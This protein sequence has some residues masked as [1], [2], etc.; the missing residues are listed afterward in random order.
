MHGGHDCFGAA[1]G[2]A[3]VGSRLYWSCIG[4]CRGVHYCFGA[5]LG[6]AGVVTTVLVLHWV[7]Q[8]WS[9]LF[10]CCTGSCRGG[11]DYVEA[12]LGHARVVTSRLEGPS[13]Q[14]INSFFSFLCFFWH[15][16]IRILQSK[17]NSNPCGSGSTLIL[18][19][20]DQKQT[21][22][23]AEGWVYGGKPS[24]TFSLLLF[25]ILS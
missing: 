13:K 23:T 4:S 3:G 16:W 24:A 18:K 17:I 10:W 6:H 5:T 1:F 14:Y 21:F 12:A 11:H 20:P 9:R 25:Y 7:M 2:H 8:G 22:I 15:T 19:N